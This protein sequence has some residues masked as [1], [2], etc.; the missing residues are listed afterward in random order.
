M[1]RYEKGTIH[2]TETRDY[3]LLRQIFQSAYATRAQL[4]EFM[5]LRGREG[6]ANAF[7][8]RLT[9]LVANGLVVRVALPGVPETLYAITEAGVDLLEIRGE[10]YAGRGCGVDRPRS[11][12]RHAV[13]VNALHL[14]FLRTG[15]LREWLPETEIYSRNTLTTRAFAKDYDAVLTVGSAGELSVA[16]GLEYEYSQKRDSDYQE[17]AIRLAGET[18]VDFVLY[19]VP[20]AYLYGKLASTFRN[21]S[22]PV[23]ICLASDLSQKV[24]DA[25]VVLATEGW[26]MTL[27]ELIEIRWAVKRGRT[28]PTVGRANSSGCR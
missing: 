16:V 19:V 1:P 15:K 2:L 21:C 14:A 17:I 24:F 25:G 9:K 4:F 23:A 20:T 6:S 3:P 26:R 12:A 28:E 11:T 5:Q 13:Q 7:K 27:Q 22:Q 10:P 18:H 8:N